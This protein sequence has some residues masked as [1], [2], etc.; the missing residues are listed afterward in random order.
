[1]FFEQHPEIVVINI[2]RCRL[3]TTL[4]TAQEP[5]IRI[6]LLFFV[7][8]IIIIKNIVKPC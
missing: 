8:I 7:I 6:V 5:F 4:Y 2:K 3:Y 1:M